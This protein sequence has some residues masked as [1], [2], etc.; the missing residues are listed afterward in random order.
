MITIPPAQG[1]AVYTVRAVLWSG[2]CP[3]NSLDQAPLL[4][5]RYS[6]RDIIIMSVSHR[7]EKRFLASTFVAKLRPLKGN[8]RKA[9]ALLRPKILNH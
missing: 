2:T 9:H 4:L 5:G 1:A 7:E 3:A 8:N 6:G